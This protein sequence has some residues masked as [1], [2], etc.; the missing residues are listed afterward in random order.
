MNQYIL[1]IRN[2]DLMPP[3]FYFIYFSQ[4]KKGEDSLNA[5]LLDN[6]YWLNVLRPDFSSC[7]IQ[8]Y[9]ARIMT[10]SPD[11]IFGQKC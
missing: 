4:F 10:F 1:K 5:R 3:T 11:T 6:M 9:L 8:S 7:K 2:A